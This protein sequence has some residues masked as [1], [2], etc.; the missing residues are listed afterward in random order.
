MTCPVPLT[1]F[2]FGNHEALV[3]N[4]VGEMAE[5]ASEA[6]ASI[7]NEALSQK[8]MAR[9]M[10]GTGNSQER[11]I[12]ALVRREDLDWSRIEVFHMDEYIGLPANHPASFRRWL[13]TRVADVARP[14]AMHYI[15]GDAPDIGEEIRRYTDL[16]LSED[17]DMSFIGFGENG[18][19]AFNDPHVAD[20]NDK[21][22]LKV[23]D[24]DEACRRQQ[25]GEGH[26]PNLESV[27]THALTVTC[28]GLFRARNWVV[29]V[30]EA[31]K[32]QAVK[33]ALTGPV[34]TACPGSLAR[35]H[36]A[37]H[38]FMDREAASLLPA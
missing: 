30:P 8:E 12:G 21:E 23:V 25:V 1:S 5:A 6:A 16:L 7:I 20:F 38:L 36:P 4:T 13:R 11:T 24:L 19:I 9:I 14:A 32:A 17:L 10:I 15:E 31:R 27:P 29:V 22:T 2:P 33:N 35:T 26:F 18:H 28:P 34:S 37:A 3:Y